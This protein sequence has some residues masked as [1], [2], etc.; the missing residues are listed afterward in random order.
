MPHD[1]EAVDTVHHQSGEGRD[2]R[3][4]QHLVGANIGDDARLQA[5][6]GAVALGG[7]VDVAEEVAAVGG[8]E[9]GLGAVLDPLDRGL[10]QSRKGGGHVL[11]AVDVDL[12]AE[13]AAHLGGD[14]AD[15]V[16]A[17]THH[18]RDQGAQDVRVLGRAPDGQVLATGLVLRD[19]AARFHRV[20]SEALVQHALRDHHV[21]LGEG[22]INSAVILGLGGLG[23]DARA[24]PVALDGDI[25]LKPL[26]Q[27][28]GVRFH[29]GLGVDD[30]GKLVVLDLD[31]VCS[32]AR[33]VAILGYDDG[34]GLA[35]V[36]HLVGR[37]REVVGRGE[38]RAN[39]HRAEVVGQL[40][41]GDDELDA[42]HGGSGARIDPR[43]DAVG[44]VAALEGEVQHARQLDVIDVGG[45]ALDEAR[46]L[47]ALDALADEL[48]KSGTVCD[49]H[50][51]AILSAAC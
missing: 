9:E 43:D 10:D 48:G 45:L 31:S 11:L 34:H 15:L 26:V 16:L 28:G 20:R 6:D 42:V 39:G 4:Q 49:G 23:I 25:A 29:R 27:G 40:R 24:T 33:D 2:H 35:D 7:E 5:R 1:G 13:A 37:H 36:A 41:P 14:G 44:D 18:R 51:C 8:G 3:G 32:V 38:G 47:A 12:A 21:R 22:R 19:H 50:D 17:Q 46:V 30:G